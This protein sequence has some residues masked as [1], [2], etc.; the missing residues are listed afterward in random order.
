MTDGQH[1]GQRRTTGGRCGRTPIDTAV[2]GGFPAVD[3][4]APATFAAADG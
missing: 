2:G 3:D 1:G 4:R